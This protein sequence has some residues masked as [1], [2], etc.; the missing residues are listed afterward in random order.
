M[1]NDK[2]SRKVMRVVFRDVN[3][4]EYNPDILSCCTKNAFHAPKT[5]AGS[6]FSTV[7][8]FLP[9]ITGR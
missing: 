2:K 1:L 7:F 3:N 8:F 5:F 6:V 4:Y 9:V